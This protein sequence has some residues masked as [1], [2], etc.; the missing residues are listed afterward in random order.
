MGFTSTSTGG[1][2]VVSMVL[3]DVFATMGVDCGFNGTNPSV[4]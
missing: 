2:L 4:I 1:S 3:V